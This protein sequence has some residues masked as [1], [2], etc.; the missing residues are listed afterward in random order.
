MTSGSLLTTTQRMQID[1]SLFFSLFFFQS[2]KAP[3][4]LLVVPKQLVG[5]SI[6]TK[7]MA[8][9]ILYAIAIDRNKNKKRPNT[10]KTTSVPLWTVEQNNESISCMK[11]KIKKQIL[12]TLPYINCFTYLNQLRTPSIIKMIQLFLEGINFGME[13][14]ENTKTLF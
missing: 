5:L 10:D 3:S 13:S 6:H 4:Q 14:N 9:A 1:Y 12:Q 7:I 11:R 2:V 8:T